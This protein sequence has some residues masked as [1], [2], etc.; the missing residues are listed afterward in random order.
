VTDREEEAAAAGE[1]EPATTA[2]GRDTYH[3]T[4]PSPEGAAC[5]WGT[6]RASRDRWMS[7]PR[8]DGVVTCGVCT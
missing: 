4:V 2:V 1:E 7:C 3:A 6:V 5:E 8:R